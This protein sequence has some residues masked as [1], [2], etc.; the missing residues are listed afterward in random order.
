MELVPLNEETVA[1]V[2]EAFGRKVI[3]R[4][5]GVVVVYIPAI[6]LAQRGN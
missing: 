4:L 6:D 2:D 5:Q 3:S 1:K